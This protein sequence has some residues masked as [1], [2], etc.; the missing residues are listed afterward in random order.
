MNPKS[1]ANLVPMKPGQT[2]N[3]GGK[4]T[5]SRNRL[6]GDFVRCLADDFERFGIYA[7]ARARHVDPVGYL[8]IVASLMPK[9][10]EISQPKDDLTLE[11][12]DAAIITLLAT[13]PADYDKSLPESR[14]IVPITQKQ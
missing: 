2:L 5:G 9:G 11:Q 1:I 13:L 6:Q 7:I 4:P 3:P 14:V 10:L 12:I 8:R